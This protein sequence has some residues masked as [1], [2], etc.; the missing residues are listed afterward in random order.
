[1]GLDGDWMS[2]SS[3]LF[4]DSEGSLAED[5]NTGS[6]L[7]HLWK[8]KHIDRYSYHHSASRD[9]VERSDHVESEKGHLFSLC[10]TDSVSEPLVRKKQ[11]LSQGS[12]QSLYRMCAG[13]RQS[14][15][16]F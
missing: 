8:R 14:Q 11:I 1:M 2:E 6:T 10:D 5:S 4:T 15:G 13:A 12:T 3:V 16:V 7:S 9:L